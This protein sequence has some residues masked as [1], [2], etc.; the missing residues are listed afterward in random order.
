MQ[1]LNS[2]VVSPL[3]ISCLLVAVVINKS[4][5]TAKKRKK[6]MS[7]CKMNAMLM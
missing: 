5:T 6:E 3:I 7:V 2:D 4:D 1:E